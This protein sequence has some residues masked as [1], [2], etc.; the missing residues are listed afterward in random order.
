MEYTQKID[1]LDFVIS[2]LKEHER[3]LDDIVHHLEKTVRRLNI[4]D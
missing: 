2:L 3:A 4:I 1:A